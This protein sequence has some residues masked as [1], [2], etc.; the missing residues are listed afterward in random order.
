MTDLRGL[1]LTINQAEALQRHEITEIEQITGD[2]LAKIDGRVRNGIASKLEQWK[3]AQNPDPAPP[4]PDPDEPPEAQWFGVAFGI[5][6]A[7]LR[8]DL[9]YV[10]K[11]TKPGMDYTAVMFDDLLTLVRPYFLKWGI[12]WHTASTHVIESR[13]HEFRDLLIM[14]DLIVFTFRFQCVEGPTGD[15]GNVLGTGWYRDIQVPSRSFD[16]FDPGADNAQGDKGPGKAHTYAQKLALRVFLNLP[17]GDDPDFTPASSLSTRG[18]ALRNELVNRLRRAIEKSGMKDV[19]IEVRTL[20]HG[21]NAKYT[22]SEENI[23]DIENQTLAKW[24]KY[25]E[26]KVNGEPEGSGSPAS[27]EAGPGQDPTS[28]PG[29]QPPAG[30]APDAAPA[31]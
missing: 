10:R 22:R 15:R 23:E 29:L 19:D 18:M 8:D 16:V 20:L 17:A 13:T 1:R 27:S 9:C 21:F 25:Y 5:R 31:E 2:V 24:A 3:L 14:E 12:S 4:E 7:E 6:I 26:D 30:S 28:L 11:L